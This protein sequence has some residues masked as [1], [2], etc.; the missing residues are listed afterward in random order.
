MRLSDRRYTL[1]VIESSGCMAVTITRDDVVLIENVR[2]V[3]ARPLLPYDWMG[4]GN[5]A[6]TTKGDNLP[7]WEDFGN[8][9]KLIY[10][11]TV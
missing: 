6:F 4:P 2:A 7:W 3:V 9:C 5:F 8:T 11:D 10:D 1:R